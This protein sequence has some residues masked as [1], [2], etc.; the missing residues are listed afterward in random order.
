MSHRSVAHRPAVLPAAAQLGC[1]ATSKAPEHLSRSE[2][3]RFYKL[4]KRQADTR[5]EVLRQEAAQVQERLEDLV[6]RVFVH[7]R[8]SW[9]TPRAVSCG[10]ARGDGLAAK[11]GPRG[12]QLT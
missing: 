11:S 2:K 8:E 1:G 5:E 6:H 3:K 12:C 7:L 9:K 4:L 10:F